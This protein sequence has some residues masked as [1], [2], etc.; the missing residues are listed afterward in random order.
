MIIALQGT[1]S[2]DDYSLF[3]RGI[4][5]ALSEI[6]PED[7]SIL[8]ASAG[9]ARVNSFAMEFTNISENSLRARNI[10]IKFIKVPPS[11]I[12]ENIAKINYF[13]YFSKPKEPVSD[14]VTLADAK[15]VEVGIYR[16]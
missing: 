5:R 15:D 14:L 7:T 8:I 10:K 13:A 16:W 1:K 12:K 2:F 6:D 4:Q 9:P 3:L 11:W